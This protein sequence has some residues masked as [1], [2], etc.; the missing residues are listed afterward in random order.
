MI[1]IKIYSK[2][3]ENIKIINNF[4]IIILVLM[5]LFFYRLPYYIDAPGGITN[6]NKRFKIKDSIS[7]SGSYNL[8]YV[9]EYNGTPILL[10]YALI[11]PN[12]DILKEKDITNGIIS[13]DDLYKIDKLNLNTS[14]DEAV[15]LAYKKAGKN[16]IIKSKKPVVMYVMEE[17]ENNLQIG[18]IILYIDEK[19]VEEQED[20][21]HIL[22]EYEIGDKVVIKV[23]NN[24][25]N[26]DRYAYI[27]EKENRKVLGIY[28]TTNYEYDTFPEI[29]FTISDNEYGSSGG[30]MTTLAI[31]DSLIE[32]DLT[33]GLKIVGTGTIDIEGNV[34]EIGGVKYKLKGAINNKADIF[35]VPNGKNNEMECKILI[36]NADENST[37]S[38][39]Y[40]S[41]TN[42]T[43]AVFAP[44]TTKAQS[45]GKITLTPKITSTTPVAH[46]SG[47]IYYTIK[48]E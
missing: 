38:E 42:T 20:L 7:S 37:A 13:M 15:I 36:S 43:L 35:F 16:I 19:K 31:Y 10:L 33:K 30:L 22:N 44:E 45:Y 14:A 27:V 29:K 28:C 46:Y 41:T 6:L 21:S 1:H 25:K 40:I 17:G 2:L 47:S 48:V 39:H 18:D 24:S 9:S 5:F 8:S 26:Y 12:W 3:K 4:I 11:N 23:E 34:G 32:K